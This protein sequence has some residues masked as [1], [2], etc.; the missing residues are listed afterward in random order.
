M[1]QRDENVSVQQSMKGH[2]GSIRVPFLSHG[3]ED[4]KKRVYVALT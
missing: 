1:T 2:W 3:G 4:D